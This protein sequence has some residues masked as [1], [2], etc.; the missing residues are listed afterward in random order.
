MRAGTT[1]LVSLGGLVA[2]LP[3]FLSAHHHS[4]PTQPAAADAADVALAP[5]PRQPQ[6]TLPAPTTTTTRPVVR[7]YSPV[8]RHYSP[9]TY[10]RPTAAPVAV[11]GSGV[12]WCIA[13]HESGGNPA[14]NTGNGF[15]GAFQFTLS[16]WRGA[17]GGPGLPSSYSYGAQLAVAQRLQQMQGWGAWPNTSRMCGV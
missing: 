11:S 16:S 17:G 14:E 7:H 12:W 8:V 2:A 6:P 3:F 10:S 1:R 4:T 9:P 13:V 15:Y 5:A